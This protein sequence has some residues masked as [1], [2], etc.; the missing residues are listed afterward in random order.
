MEQHQRQGRGVANLHAGSCVRALFSL[1]CVVCAC[2]PGDFDGACVQCCAADCFPA[3]AHGHARAGADQVNHAKYV[4][5]DRRVN[6]G[7]SNMA[8]G[9]FYNT[10]GASFNSNSTTLRAAL[11]QIFLRDW[12]S[13]YAIPL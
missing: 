7:T 11:E 1:S 4:V 10:A 12:N 2:L 5:T 13:P 9:Y 3:N 6:I 8:W